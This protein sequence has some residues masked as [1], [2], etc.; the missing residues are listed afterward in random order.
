MAEPTPEQVLLDSMIY[1]KIR[2]AVEDE[3]E[4]CID[5]AKQYCNVRLSVSP[6]EWEELEKAMRNP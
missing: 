5:E 1:E 3:R 6:R 2:D 4:R